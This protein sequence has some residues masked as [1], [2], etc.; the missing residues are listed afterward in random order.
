MEAP[1]Q[2]T[3]PQAPNRYNI[4]IN[5]VD[6]FDVSAI[7]DTDATANEVTEN[8]VIG[9]TVGITADAFDPMPPTNDHLPIP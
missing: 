3:V 7:T 1:H 9:T 5:D 8:V 4:A 2:T 6:E